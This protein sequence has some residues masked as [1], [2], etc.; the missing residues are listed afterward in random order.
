M[1]KIPAL[2]AASALVATL[3]A[4]TSTGPAAIDGC[5][6]ALGSG[7]SSDLVTATGSVGSRPTVNFPTPLIAKEAEVTRLATGEGEPARAGSQI[8]F[9]FSIFIGRSGQAVGGT[10]YDGSNV[11]RLAATEDSSRQAALICARPGD[12][13]ALTT[14]VADAYGEGA[15]AAN[16]IPDDESLVLVIDVLAAYPGKA[17]GFNQLPE[18]GMP[19]V[20]TAVDGTPGISVP[21]APAPQELRISTIKAGAGAEIAEGDSVVVHYSGWIWPEPGRTPTSFDS[22]WA[23]GTAATFLVDETQLIS[24]FVEALVGAKVGDQVLAVIPPDQGYDDGQTRIFVIDVL[25]IAE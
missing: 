4:C 18:D 22:S 13:L 6:P 14:T 1:R 5:S 20:V 9:E 23:N 19:T 2:L 7:A 11:Q 25:G 3:A 10:G 8:D 24:G 21:A 16:G 12:R 15:L 17:D